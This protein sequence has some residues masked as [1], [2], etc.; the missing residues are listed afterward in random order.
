MN[1]T[2]FVYYL[3]W[4]VKLIVI[5]MYLNILYFDILSLEYVLST[6][7]LSSKSKFIILNIINTNGQGYKQLYID[8]KDRRG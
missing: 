8:R 2:S 6:Y 7:F 5:I 3:F 4:E 1:N